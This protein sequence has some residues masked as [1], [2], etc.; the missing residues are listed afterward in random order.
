MEI[1]PLSIN[2]GVYKSKAIQI[3]NRDIQ[4]KEQEKG[5][6]EQY[7]KKKLMKN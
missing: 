6:S 5:V 4:V 7:E 3:S 2:E 1:N